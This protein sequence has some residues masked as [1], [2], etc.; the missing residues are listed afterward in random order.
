MA[1]V[2]IQM[3]SKWHDGFLSHFIYVCICTVYPL[4]TSKWI[5][6]HKWSETC[7]VCMYVHTYSWIVST[8]YSVPV[9]I[10]CMYVHK[11]TL[12]VSTS[13]NKYWFCVTFEVRTRQGSLYLWRTL[14]RY[15]DRFSPWKKWVKCYFPYSSIFQRGQ[16]QLKQWRV[17]SE[18]ETV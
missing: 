1:S 13:D 4:E 15:F 8:P 11:P 12:M 9:Y 16:S 7:L 3:V 6:T 10:S 18:A 14:L 17:V 5:G 2:N